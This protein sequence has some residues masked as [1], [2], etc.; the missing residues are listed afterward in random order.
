MTLLLT[1]MMLTQSGHG[2][3][4]PKAGSLPAG[5]GKGEIDQQSMPGAAKVTA[6][7]ECQFECAR[8][9][10]NCTMPFA[11][12]AP[13]DANNEDKRKAFMAASKDCMKKT[14]P[15]FQKCEKL[16]TDKGGGSKK[17]KE[18]EVTG[19]GGQPKGDTP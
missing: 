1:L 17:G 19:G 12:R 5:Q 9:M 3:G 14:G 18:I 10:R 2:H 8:E 4:Q 16:K 7:Q 11:P 15:C 6:E 13:G